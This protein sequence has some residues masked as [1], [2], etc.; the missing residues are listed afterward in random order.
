MSWMNHL[1]QRM[2]AQ[3]ITPVNKEKTMIKDGVLH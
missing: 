2:K 1:F 3:E